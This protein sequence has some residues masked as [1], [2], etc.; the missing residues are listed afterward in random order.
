MHYTILDPLQRRISDGRRDE[1]LVVASRIRCSVEKAKAIIDQ[2]KSLTRAQQISPVAIPLR[3]IFEAAC[4]TAREQQVQC[5]IECPA[6]LTVFADP[7]RLTETFD[8][9]ASNAAHWFDKSSKQ[10]KI[11]ASAIDT[12]L[13]DSLDS[14][15]TYVRVRFSDNGVGVPVANKERIF[16]AFMTTRDQGTGLGLALVRRI[17]EGHGGMIREIGIPGQGA[18]FEIYLPRPVVSDMTKRQIALSR[19]SSGDASQRRQ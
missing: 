2:F 10:I 17:I 9:L 12:G 7:D 19:S 1:A 14:S 5:D 6:D 15:R 16:D 13:P 18:D 4:E 3:T 8:E 11:T